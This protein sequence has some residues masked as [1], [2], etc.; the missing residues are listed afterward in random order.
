MSTRLDKNT[1]KSTQPAA[2]KPKTDETEHPVDARLRKLNDEILPK[3]PYILSCPASLKDEF[4]KTHYPQNVINW[5]KFSLFKP[6]EEELQYL[7]FK[8]RSDDGDIRAMHARGGWDDGKGRIA[9]LHEPYSRASSDGTPRQGPAPKKKIT[10]A[11][12]QNK[13]RSKAATPT[14]K[15]S[16]P[17]HKEPPDS[18]NQD[19]TDIALVKESDK[20]QGAEYH[21]QKR[22]V[23]TIA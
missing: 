14:P 10:L 15:P 2:T 20:P 7:T 23:V 5:K 9:T 6:G 13:D 22:C 16:A 19:T 8:D 1:E 11:E 18:A 3:A 12:Y 17:E 4:V 21:G